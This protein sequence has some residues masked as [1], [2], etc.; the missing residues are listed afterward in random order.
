MCTFQLCNTNNIRQPFSKQIVDL[1]VPIDL[2]SNILGELKLYLVS[3]TKNQ[4]SST[5]DTLY[6]TNYVEEVV[7]SGQII[8]LELSFLT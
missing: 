2:V 3:K 5:T 7:M 1:N 8:F 6:C 4:L